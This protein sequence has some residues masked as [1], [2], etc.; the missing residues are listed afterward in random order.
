MPKSRQRKNHKQK[1]QLRNQKIS[2]AKRKYEKAQKE[3]L[4]KLIEMEKERGLFNNLPQ[5]NP[6][7]NLENTQ[8][9][10]PII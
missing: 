3:M 8:F 5:I 9:D 1:M 2:D 4:M 6:E 7:Q 10:G